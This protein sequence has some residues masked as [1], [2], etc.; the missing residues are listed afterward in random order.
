MNLALGL[1][2]FTKDEGVGLDSAA[3]SNCFQRV[4]SVDLT[5]GPGTG[6]ADERFRVVQ[7]ADEG[8]EGSDGHLISQNDGCVAE[9]ATATRS[10]ERCMA[11]AEA[12]GVVVEI[13]EGDEIDWTRKGTQ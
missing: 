5:E 9:N 10:P 4:R 7:A 2:K 13:E 8:G 11:E 12:E 3:L 6:T 1:A